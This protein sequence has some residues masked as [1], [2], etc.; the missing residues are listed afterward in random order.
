LDRRKAVEQGRLAGRV[1][2]VELVEVLGKPGTVI[3]LAGC[4]LLD[5]AIALVEDEG[6]RPLGPASSSWTNVHDDA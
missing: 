4:Q 2:W 6:I 3:H 1:E 5:W